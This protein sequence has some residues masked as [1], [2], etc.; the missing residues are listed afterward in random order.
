M[1]RKRKCE[2]GVL[3]FRMR[4]GARKGSG[5]KPKGEKAGVPHRVRAE[6]K[7]RYPVLVTMSVAK[8]LPGLR[9]GKVRGVLWEAFAKGCERDGFRMVEF[10]VQ[11]DHL[12]LIVEGRD[13]RSLCEGLRGLAV[14]IARALNKVWQRTGQVFGDRYHDRI[15]KTPREVK[16]A[17]RYVLQNRAPRSGARSLPPWR[18][19]ELR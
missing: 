8:G 2:Q 14:R 17:L 10:S 4:G 19:E 1:G 11:E 6:L 13:R 12:H 16:N 3:P 9:S 18:L 5:P 15:L 7:G